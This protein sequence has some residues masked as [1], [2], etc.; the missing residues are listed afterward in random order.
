ML[1]LFF[2]LLSNKGVMVRYMK[3]SLFIVH[4]SQKEIK[5]GKFP[6]APVSLFVWFSEDLASLGKTLGRAIESMIF[7]AWGRCKGCIH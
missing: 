3:E 4:A 1:Q 2:Q 7:E 6:L 5:E